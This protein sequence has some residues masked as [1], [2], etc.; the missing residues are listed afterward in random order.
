[1]ADDGL[2]QHSARR[3]TR[4]RA[5]LIFPSGAI[6]ALDYLQAA[7]HMPGM[8]LRLRIPQA[9]RR[10]G[11]R[12]AAPGME[13]PLTQA[14]VLFEGPAREAAWRYPQNLN[15]AASVALSGLG[16][17]ATQVRIVVDPSA[18]GNT[19]RVSA[20]GAFGQMHLD[21]VNA[22]SP[23]NPKTSWV[24]GWS[25]LATVERRLCAGGIGL[26]CGTT[27]LPQLNLAGLPSEVQGGGLPCARAIV[28]AKRWLCGSVQSNTMLKW[29]RC[30]ASYQASGLP[31]AAHASA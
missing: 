26:G 7:R 29:L 14:C 8:Q 12:V 17:D 15:V 22:P 24:V 27:L 6:G 3:A 13:L 18:T 25:L 30:G 1:M 5:K 31:C 28:A 2:Y 20:Q 16:M 9:A 21:I 11:G 4:G 19:H 23:D 10:L